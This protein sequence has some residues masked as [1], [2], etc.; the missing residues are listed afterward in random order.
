MSRPRKRTLELWVRYEHGQGEEF[1]GEIET[2]ANNEDT[3]WALRS[4]F[5]RRKVFVCGMSLR[6]PRKQFVAQPQKQLALW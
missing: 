4:D 3:L 1:C 2:Q 6:A 5:E